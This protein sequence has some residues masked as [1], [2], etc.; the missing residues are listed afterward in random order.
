MEKRN[1]LFGNNFV[2][3][4]EFNLFVLAS[5]CNLYL[6]LCNVHVNVSIANPATFKAFVLLFVLVFV[7]KS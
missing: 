6:V 3:L 5:L 4:F 1:T 2:F 7:A